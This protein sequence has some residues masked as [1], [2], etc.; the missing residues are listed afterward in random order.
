MQEYQDL[1]LN[2]CQI[3]QCT[4]EHNAK[5]NNTIFVLNKYIRKSDI[6]QMICLDCPLKYVEKSITFHTSYREHIQEISS[7]NPDIQ[8]TY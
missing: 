1:K 8:I 7:N 6:Y 3:C 2:Y 5:H 4:T